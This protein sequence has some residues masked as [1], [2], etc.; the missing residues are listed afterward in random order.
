MTGSVH[1]STDT[2]NVFMQGSKDSVVT[3]VEDFSACVSTIKDNEEPTLSGKTLG[4]TWLPHTDGI[5]YGARAVYS[6][7]S[8]EDLDYWND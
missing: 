6:D 8:T 5:S 1:N 4:M 2:V 7:A 3:N